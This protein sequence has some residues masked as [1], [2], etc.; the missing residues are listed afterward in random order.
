M[1]K[2]DVL[3]VGAGLYGAVVAEVLTSAGKTC[4]VVD[5]RDQIGGNVY[6]RE[7]AGIHVHVY[8]PHIFHTNNEL[9]WNY[10]NRFCSFRPFV[11]S[12]IANYKGE[13][14]NLPFNM[15]TFNK[16]WGVVTPAEARKKIEEQRLQAGVTAVSNLEE[17]AI[18]MVGTDLYEKLIKGYTSK[19]WGRPCSE[20]PPFIIE[21]LPVRFQYDNNYYN[22]KYQGIPEE[23]YTKL[24]E[25][26]L[27]G[28]DV[29][30]NTDFLDNKEELSSLAHTV[31]YSGAI[32][33]YFQYC[34]GALAYRSVSFET[35]ILD[36]E[37]YQGNAVVNFTDADTPYTRIIEHKH[38]TS[39]TQPKT[40][41][42]R[43]YS[44]EWKPGMEPYYPVND[45]KNASL[46]ARYREL[47]EAE[48]HVFF[49]GRLGEFRYYDM[50][51]VVEQALVLAEKMIKNG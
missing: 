45:E 20:L 50:D 5:K 2:Y 37:N 10:V 47:A 31:V 11:N 26:M 48:E 4:L 13:I 12:P 51:T 24:V 38:F 18:S 44:R 14:Y 6:T 32:D 21:R 28:A 36:M 23:G 16:L 33:A 39:G 19:Q 15:N 9:V 40:V 3:I 34:F 22:A 49:V 29:I 43:E 46:Y 41:I 30:L 42:S 7:V 35:E 27:D 8:G 17:K 1:K 25:R